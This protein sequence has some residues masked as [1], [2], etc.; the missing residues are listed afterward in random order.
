VYREEGRHNSATQTSDRAGDAHRPGAARPPPGHASRGPRAARRS[1]QCNAASGGLANGAGPAGAPDEATRHSVRNGVIS[2]L[3]A[4]A[5][6]LV[7]NSAGLRTW[8]HGLPG[9]AATDVVVKSADW[10]HSVMQRAGVAAAMAAVR[11]AV[12]EL[13]NQHWPDPDIPRQAEPISPR[14]IERRGGATSPVIPQVE[15]SETIPNPATRV[16]PREVPDRSAARPW[17]APRR[18]G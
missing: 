14:T 7:F 11:D 4:A 17:L 12:A 6:L 2:M 5:V 13:R 18:P 1:Q 16:E 8:A 9:N 15:R 10:W 3:V